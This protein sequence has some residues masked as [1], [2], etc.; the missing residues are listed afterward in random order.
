MDTVAYNTA[1]KAMGS[2]KAEPWLGLFFE[3]QQLGQCPCRLLSVA[4]STC[5]ARLASWIMR[6]RPSAIEELWS[7]GEGGALDR[8]VKGLAIAGGREVTTAFVD[9]RSQSRQ[10][11]PVEVLLALVR[12]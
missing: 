11:R 3:M 2:P 7:E 12:A 4:G 10:T 6:S 8:L 1:I 9:E 5:T